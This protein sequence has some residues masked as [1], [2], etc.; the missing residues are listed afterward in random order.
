MYAIAALALGQSERDTAEVILRLLFLGLSDRQILLDSE[1]DV[2]ILV[3]LHESS[4]IHWP[5]LG[6]G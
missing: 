1:A 2:A 6:S 3:L 4:G 5:H